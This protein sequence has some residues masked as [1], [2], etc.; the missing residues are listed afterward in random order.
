MS[1]CLHRLVRYPGCLLLLLMILVFPEAADA[2]KQ[3]KARQSKAPQPSLGT[4]VAPASAKDWVKRQ[5][6]EGQP[7]VLT[8]SYL[9]QVMKG[10]AQENQKRIEETALIPVLEQALTGLLKAAS[11]ENTRRL[12]GVALALLVENP[13]VSPEAVKEAQE[14]KSNPMFSPRGH[15]TETVALQRY[16]VAMQYLAKATVDVSIRKDRFPFP[17]SMLFPLETAQAIQTLFSDPTNKDA[18]NGWMIVHS[19]YSEINGSPDLPTFAD[20]AEIAKESKLTKEA[21]EQWA[22]ARKLPRINLERGLGIQPFGERGTLHEFVIDDMKSHFMS[23]DTPRDKIGEIIR[24][25]NLM[26]GT[27]VGGKH[28][29]G[30]D[31]RIGAQ[32]SDI[33]YMKVL[34]AISVGAKG[35]ETSLFK[36]N[37]FAGCMTSLAEQTA[38][39]AKVSILVQ[40]SAHVEKPIP[41]G[42]KVYLEPNSEEFLLALAKASSR[43]SGICSRTAKTALGASARDAATT[44]I[45]PAL[46]ALAKLAGESRKLGGES[47]PVETGSPLWKEYGIHLAEL[48][49]KPSVTVD[50]FQVKERSG[51][52]YYFQWAIA[53]YEMAPPLRKKGPKPTGMEMVFF[54]AWNDEIAP[55]AQGPI[56]N[57]Q[58]EGRVL[59]GNLGKL[60]P[61]I[62]VPNGRGL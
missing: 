19:F 9:F 3:V 51:N 22:S 61:L 39:M 28:I 43:M 37:L 41:A 36:K 52:V 33:Y 56:N 48:A 59:E 32:E 31:E 18:V 29:N 10:I 21:V 14:I 25:E 8:N 4:T 26:K 49:R 23:D 55:G 7:V 13:D 5:L 27:T 6:L 35:W 20:L 45:S 44:D 30:L 57:L 60:H 24:F 11:E 46:E 53:P 2:Q 54:E 17:E 34:R 16:F 42:A 12:F 15:Y 50:V 62:P 47:R 58:W 38:L 40:K 1:V